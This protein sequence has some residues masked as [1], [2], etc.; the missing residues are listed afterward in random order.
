MPIALLRNVFRSQVEEKMTRMEIAMRFVLCLLLVGFLSACGGGGGGNAFVPGSGVDTTTIDTRLRAANGQ[1]FQPSGTFTGLTRDTPAS[2][3]NART[4]LRELGALQAA[5]EE[6]TPP[7]FYQQL[8][9]GVDAAGNAGDYTIAL[10]DRNHSYRVTHSHGETQFERA[11]E[12]FLIYNYVV[13]A[14]GSYRLIFDENDIEGSQFYVWDAA[15]VPSSSVPNSGNAAYDLEGRGTLT[16]HDAHPPDEARGLLSPNLATDIYEVILTGELTADFG[17][18]TVG[19]YLESDYGY[20]VGGTGTPGI[21]SDTGF[22]RHIPEDI[23]AAKYFGNDRTNTPSELTGSVR[24][25]FLQGQLVSNGDQYT[26]SRGIDVSFLF[27][28]CGTRNCFVS[29]VGVDPNIATGDFAGLLVGSRNRRGYMFG[30]FV[31][32]NEEEVFG[33]FQV[34]NGLDVVRVS[35]GTPV[36]ALGGFF[37][38]AKQPGQN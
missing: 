21:T 20:R 9:S 29:D 12:T 19:G 31:G 14:W 5:E 22:I 32:P 7:T 13:V 2:E 3:S 8:L 36:N 34:I 35:P 28:S 10:F 6:M 25:D 16:K 33:N 37:V 4:V 17:A 27:D 26:R 18:D 38:G 23:T 30:N 15:I 24:M 1:E 11:L